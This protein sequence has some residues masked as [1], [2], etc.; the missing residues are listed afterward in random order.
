MAAVLALLNGCS[1]FGSGAS[2]D[3][4]PIV[5]PP[6]KVGSNDLTTVVNITPAELNS[7]NHNVPTT[8]KK[9]VSSSSVVSEPRIQE[10]RKNGGVVSEIKVNNKGDVPDYY[11]YP[12]QQQQDSVV[13]NRPD[14]NVSTPNWQ[15][16]W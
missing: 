9:A 6:K 1:L 12:S 5:S 7:K 14:M 8:S 4:A 16:N 15:I 10:E 11:I 3:E 2:A 13:N